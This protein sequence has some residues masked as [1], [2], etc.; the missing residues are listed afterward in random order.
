VSLPRGYYETYCSMKSQMFWG[1]TREDGNLHT[2]QK[3]KLEENR[4]FEWERDFMNFF[5]KVSRTRQEKKENFC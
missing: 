2:T 5:E 4:V 1:K 3:E